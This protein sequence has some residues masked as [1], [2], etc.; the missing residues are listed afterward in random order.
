MLSK[1]SNSNTL[2]PSMQQQRDA[3]LIICIPCTDSEREGEALSELK[4]AWASS[5][6]FKQYFI[7]LFWRE[8]DFS[9]D[10]GDKKAHQ[11]EKG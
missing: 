3:L 2:I 5:A 1:R 10:M 6:A 4:A 8:S 11:T 9:S 7:L